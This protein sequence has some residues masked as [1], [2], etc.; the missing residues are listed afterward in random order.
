[1]EA[2][3]KSQSLGSVEEAFQLKSFD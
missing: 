1:M 3:V 2:Y